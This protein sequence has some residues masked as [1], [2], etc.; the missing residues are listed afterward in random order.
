[1][2]REKMTEKRFIFEQDGN[3]HTVM[4][5]VENKP[6]GVFEFKE[7]EFP[8]YACFHMIIDKMNELH[9]ENEYLCEKIK[10]NEWHWNTIDEDRDVW[11]YKCKRLEEENK[12]LKQ[13]NKRLEEKI[14]RER[15]SFT[16]THERWRK[17]AE[18]KNKELAE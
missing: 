12:Q 18:N 4:D 6:M 8:A 2:E 14:Q 17:E 3:F 9:E 13:R 7:N 16:K 1:M 10:E 5:T 11:I 15:T